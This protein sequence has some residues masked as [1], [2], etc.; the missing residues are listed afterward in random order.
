MCGYQNRKSAEGPGRSALLLGRFSTSRVSANE[1]ILRCTARIPLAR[2]GY[3]RIPR[4]L[5]PWKALSPL[6][7]LAQLPLAAAAQAYSGR[8]PLAVAATCL[9]EAHHL[10]EV[11]VSSG[12]QVPQH[13]ASLQVFSA[14]LHLPRQL[15]AP[16]PPTRPPPP[17]LL[18]HRTPSYLPMLACKTSLLHLARAAL[19]SSRHPTSPRTR[20]RTLPKRS[21]AF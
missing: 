14:P 16:L 11:E 6:F 18:R 8:P 12:P 1:R 20:T 4:G 7:R 9:E 13:Q 19:L 5:S 10:Q 21:R 17:Q 15:R 3:T 2:L